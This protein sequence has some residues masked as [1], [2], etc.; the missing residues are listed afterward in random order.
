M[1]VTLFE[2]HQL[3]INVIFFPRPRVNPVSYCIKL[4]CRLL[5]LSFFF[6]FFLC[7]WLDP[8]EEYW[9]RFFACPN[10]RLLSLLSGSPVDLLI[11]YSFSKKPAVSLA[12]VPHLLYLSRCLTLHH[13]LGDVWSPWFVLSKNPVGSGFAPSSFPPTDPHTAPTCLWCIQNWTPNFSTPCKI[14]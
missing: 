2:F 13:S 12:K 5:N 4:S 10:F 3:S 8:L 1:L 6:F 9:Q 11:K 7:H 14:P